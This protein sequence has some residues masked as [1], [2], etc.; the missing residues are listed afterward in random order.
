MRAEPFVIDAHQHFWNPHRVSYSWLGPDLA[1]INRVIEF[2]ELAPILAR[3]GIGGTV[4]VQSA[5][6]DEDTDYMLA[7]AAE[8][9]QIL[10]VVGYVPLERPD[11]AAAR[12]HQLRANEAVVGIRSLIH[13]Q[14]D[15]DWLLRPEV[16]RGLS[17]LE[18]ADVSMDIV[19]VLPRHLEHVPAIAD[20]HPALRLVI[21]HLSKPPIKSPDWEPWKTLITKAARQPNVY[22]KLSGLY[23]AQGDPEDWTAADVEP[24]VQFALELFGPQR[25]MYG[26]DWP[27]SMLS[28]GYD[29]VWKEL[30]TIFGQLSD[31]ERTAVLSETAIAF[32]RI[33]DAR[34]QAVRS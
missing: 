28:G 34:L 24:Y 2:D 6:N 21:D 14:P 7:V 10:A 29:K 18:A 33:P 32:Y 16:D 22:A 8:H 23:P 19:S 27:I 30:S 13:N 17:V 3:H 11:Q 26:G 25:L 31:A 9:P 15:P 1:P 5:D 12:L 20:R 4:L